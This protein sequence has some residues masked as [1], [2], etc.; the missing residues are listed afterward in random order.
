MPEVREQGRDKKQEI[1]RAGAGAG[2]KKLRDQGW[3]GQE[4]QEVRDQLRAGEVTKEQLC[5]FESREVHKWFQ[6]S[7]DRCL[8]HWRLTK[9]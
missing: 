6:F 1:K 2:G 7:T 9:C 5:I 4:P 8:A 3:C